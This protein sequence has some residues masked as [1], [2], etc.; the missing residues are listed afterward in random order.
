MD[1]NVIAYIAGFFDGDGHVSLTKLSDDAVIPHYALV[2]G[3]T[4][5]ERGILDWIQEQLGMGRVTGGRKYK[6]PD[7]KATWQL[8]FYGHNAEAVLKTLKPYLRVKQA[9]AELGLEF[10]TQLNGRLI[11]DAGNRQLRTPPALQT[12]R[13]QAYIQMRN[14]NHRGA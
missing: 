9:R 10:A 6:P 7:Q 8:R 11:Q 14:L 13:E 4:Q 1:N 3:I 12:R 2:V 5:T